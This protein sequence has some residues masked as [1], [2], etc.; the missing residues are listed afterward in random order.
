MSI[1]SRILFSGAFIFGSVLANYELRRHQFKT[2]I[3]QFENSDEDTQLL[4]LHNFS[5]ISISRLDKSALSGICGYGDR[6]LLYDDY[7][8]LYNSVK[9]NDI[10]SYLKSRPGIKVWLDENRSELRLT[11]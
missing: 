6:H 10:K 9:G 7:G 4:K 11:K 1:L 2:V 3:I 8:S 5:G